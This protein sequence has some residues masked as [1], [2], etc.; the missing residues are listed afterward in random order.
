LTTQVGLNATIL[1]S[2][3]QK[4]HHRLTF[5]A[6]FKAERLSMKTQLFI[7]VLALLT[8]AGAVVTDQSLTSD[9]RIEQAAS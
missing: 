5:L 2:V 8:R 7:S 1:P 6:T 3:V 4:K 9:Q